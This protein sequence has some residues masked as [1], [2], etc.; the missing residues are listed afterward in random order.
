MDV[1]DALIMVA[2]ENELFSHGHD[3]QRSKAAVDDGFLVF[4]R[5]GETLKVFLKRK[6]NGNIVQLP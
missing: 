5:I 4:V 2:A 6:L 3:P 1:C